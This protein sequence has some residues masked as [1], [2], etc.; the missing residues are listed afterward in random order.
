MFAKD[1]NSFALSSLEVENHIITNLLNNFTNHNNI[2][3]KG[4]DCQFW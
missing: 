1:A 4:N 2:N 3:Y